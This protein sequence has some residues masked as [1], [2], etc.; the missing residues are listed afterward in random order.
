MIDGLKTFIDS[1]Q[2][3]HAQEISCDLCVIGTGA[4]GIT[5]AREFAGR[6]L[7]VVMLESG[8]LYY[9]EE[10][11][12]LAD[13]V[14]TG[15]GYPEDATRLRFFGGTTYHWGGHCVPLQ[16]WVFEGREWMGDSAWPLSRQDLDPYYA[17]AH[18]VL[19]IG[20]FDYDP[21]PVAERLGHPLLPFDAARVETVL[22]RYHRLQF[23]E[24]YRE[25]LDRA[26]NISVLL[27]ATVAS[28][29][30][31]EDTRQVTGVS[32]KTSAE[33]QFVVRPKRVVLA[34]GGIENARLLLLSNQQI[35]AGVGNQ[36]DLVGRYFA[37]HIWYRSG[38][39][40]P[41]SQSPEDL[42]IYD[43][44]I[45]FEG[46]YAVR[47]HLALPE[48]RLRELQI[49][50]YRSE[51]QVKHT[52]RFHE[53]TDAAVRIRRHLLDRALDEISL[54]DIWSLVTDPVPPASF[55]FDTTSGPLVYGFGNYVEQ[56]PNPESRVLLSSQ[57]DALGMPRPELRWRLTS[58][59][60]AGIAKAQEVIAA[61]VGRAGVGRMNIVIP[62]PAQAI[63]GAGYGCHHMGTTRMHVD[64]K[65]GVVDADAR[66]HGLENLFIAGSSV[67][68]SFG[69]ANP[70]LTIVAMSLRLA[71]HLKSSTEAA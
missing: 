55:W 22:S 15:H 7:K 36:H 28:L 69:Y 24:R 48:A 30:L 17:R 60:M 34:A 63:E 31:S 45:P 23:G 52:Y 66:V 18:D 42:E 25:E 39:I 41:S 14:V 62:D 64:P 21:A 9:E 13:L 33:R 59:D 68:P 51:L 4:A 56:I 27:H 29:D 2:I 54:D 44:E 3:P 35:A 38:F 5:I 61:E 65:R 16:P 26:G 47:C 50:G 20:P 32:V 57:R 1:R 10:A 71:D 6:D 11:Q 58:A 46:D 12:D 8:G 43:S 53:S 37:D 40:L 19:E 49:P 70:T 67:F